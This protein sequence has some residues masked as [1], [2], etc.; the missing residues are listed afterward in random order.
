MFYLQKAVIAANHVPLVRTIL[1]SVYYFALWILKRE[2]KHHQIILG[3]YIRNS[4]AEGTWV[5]GRSDIDITVVLKG[6][7][8]LIE[9]QIS[10]K[11]FQ[12]RYAFL[13][14]ILPM[15]GEAEYLLET[16]VNAYCSYSYSGYQASHWKLIYGEDLARSSY[17]NDPDTI[18]TDRLSHLVSTYI[19]LFCSKF[20]IDHWQQMDLQILSRIVKKAERLSMVEKPLKSDFN[21][22]FE[23]LLS[24]MKLMDDN[25]CQYLSQTI[26]SIPKSKVQAL[27]SISIHPD[28]KK[29]TFDDKGEVAWNSPF[30]RG[31]VFSILERSGSTYIIL[32]DRLDDKNIIVVF[33]TLYQLFDNLI[34]MTLPTFQF[35]LTYC[36]PIH[37]A[38][39]LDDG[40]VV[41][42]ED[43]LQYIELPLPSTLWTAFAN[44]SVAMF[45][46]IYSQDWPNLDNEY[47][48]HRLQGWYLRSLFFL[49]KEELMVSYDLIEKY[50]AQAYPQWWLKIK[51]ADPAL[52]YE[53]IRKICDQ[54]ARRLEKQPQSK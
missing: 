47:Y 2:C 48:K 52:R 27:P 6:N 13:Q 49:E 46:D 45:S 5:A 38:I 39:L 36:D 20:E 16:H 9:E 22:P 23:A 37:C 43:V 53:L 11:S 42:G 4:F 32:K 8:E 51:A 40:R 7:F 25:C 10:L 30:V 15:L 1:R 34:F 18:A 41:A 24:I 33:E 50:C 31:V 17:D 35:Y 28:K 14:R 21:N 44:N 12:K 19:H 54:V 3:V 26:H 29:D